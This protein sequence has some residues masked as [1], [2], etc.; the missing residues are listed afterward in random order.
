[1]DDGSGN[2]IQD[3]SLWGL[4]FEVGDYT[5]VFGLSPREQELLGHSPGQLEYWMNM[6]SMSILGPGEANS[7]MADIN[8]NGSHLSTMTPG[9]VLPTGG[10]VQN[11]ANTG[12]DQLRTA[13]REALLSAV[14]RLV[15][16]SSMM[17]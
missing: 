11:S 4:N 17:Q 5:G 16:L 6:D 2:P 8:S 15:Q 3:N 14:D 10:H 9:L 1:M 7:V 13:Q 12:S